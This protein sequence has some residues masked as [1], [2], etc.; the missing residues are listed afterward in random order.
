MYGTKELSRYNKTENELLKILIKNINKHLQIYKQGYLPNTK[1]LIEFKL[2]KRSAKEYSL[3]FDAET[4]INTFTE[5]HYR[6]IEFLLVTPKGEYIWFDAKHSDTTTNI[7]DLHGE[8]F[9]ASNV[10]NL[11]GIIY[12]V[13]AGKGYSNEIIRQHE[14]F[15]TQFNI[16][17]VKII[18]IENVKDILF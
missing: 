11:K 2:S 12:Y 3:F 16:T 1:E 8:Y 18:R 17:N 13:V 14:E 9:R 7:T 5:Q 10:K 15:L 6:K 4:N